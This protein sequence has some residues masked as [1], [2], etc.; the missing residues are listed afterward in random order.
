MSVT[1]T[2]NCG[3]SFTVTEHRAGSARRCHVCGR[4]FRF[5]DLPRPAETPKEQPAVQ[6]L[7]T[8][9]PTDPTSADTDVRDLGTLTWY[10]GLHRFGRL[11]LAAVL[12]AVPVA[13]WTGLESP[14]PGLLVFG[15]VALLVVLVVGRFESLTLETGP[16]G[17]PVLVCRRFVC[18]CSKGESVYDLAS[19]QSLALNNTE[20][21]EREEGFA[22]FFVGGVVGLFPTRS[23]TKAGK[24]QLSL[25]VPDDGEEVIVFG[26]HSLRKVKQIVAAIKQASGLRVGR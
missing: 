2:C 20:P 11:V 25:R 1:Y 13:L 15:L 8:E 5:P 17:Q 7:S 16:D 10:T 19:Y 9:F 14:I 23:G 21:R 18:F 3:T 4:K 12:L 24:W 22:F 26:D 6:P